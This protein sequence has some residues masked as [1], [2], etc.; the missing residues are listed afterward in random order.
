LN[1]NQIRTYRVTNL[2]IKGSGQ[3]SSEPSVRNG[4]T[5]VSSFGC[6]EQ[7]EVKSP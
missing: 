4:A 2:R 5:P 6:E 7:Q 1:P 3:L